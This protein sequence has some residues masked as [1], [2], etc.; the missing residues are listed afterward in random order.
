V[1]DLLANLVTGR[2][3]A[4]ALAKDAPMHTDDNA[5]LEFRGPRTM[6]DVEARWSTRATVEWVREA[7]FFFLAPQKGDAKARA[8]IDE[9]VRFVEARGH[10]SRSQ[11]LAREGDRDGAIEALRRA[12]VLNRSDPLL[13]EVLRVSR[14]A[15]AAGFVREKRYAAAE[16]IY[17]RVLK[18]D[19]RN[20][21]AHYGLAYALDRRGKHTDALAHYTRAIE[22]APQSPDYHV[23]LADVAFRLKHYRRAIAHFRCA[24]ELRKDWPPAMHN[25]AWALVVNPARTRADLDEAVELAER[26][27]ELTGWKA[28]RMIDT[29]ARIYAAVGRRG[30]A[31]A[32]LQEALV[33]AGKAGDSARAGRLRKTI[34]KYRR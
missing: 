9:G 30:D 29:L 24:L 17:R 5:L 10:V 4:R 1:P 12:S 7:D 21:E 33:R 2:D 6:L 11:L 31:I 28:E 25:L 19:P 18:I 20:P 13:H 26:A 27:C 14:L 34:S 22:E 15:A 23:A 32:L 3:G 8:V 16:E